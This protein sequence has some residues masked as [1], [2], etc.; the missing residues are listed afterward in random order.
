[1]INVKIEGNGKGED[2][3]EVSLEEEYSN[4]GLI[5]LMAQLKELNMSV[6]NALVDD[7]GF[8]ERDVSY[9]VGFILL[10]IIG[11]FREERGLLGIF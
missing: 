1:M 6:L 2:I 11:D 4:D 7:C 10:H 3:C 8:D 9:Y 5:H